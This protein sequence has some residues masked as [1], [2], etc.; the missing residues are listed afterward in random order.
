[1]RTPSMRTPVVVV[2]ALLAAGCQTTDPEGSAPSAS[3]SATESAAPPATGTA[4]PCLTGSWRSTDA[5][6]QA[7]GGG[8]SGTISGGS[9]ALVTI[10]ENGA[11]TAD[12]SG[13]QPADFTAKVGNTDVKG[14]FTYAG[15][16]TGTVRTG[17]G[18]T[19]AWEPVPPVD[20][21]D[22][23]LTVELTE[24][25][26]VKVFDGVKI[27]DYLGDGADRTGNVVD[28]DPF[29]GAGRYECRG[30]TLVLAPSDDTGITWTLARA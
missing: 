8:A 5:T 7:S 4:A 28:V 26:K 2:L 16:V 15:K 1:M 29:L 23:R 6:G 9:G 3:P 10:G 18:E 14:R 19:G 30:D 21:G 22:T 17:T 25:L 24:P 12:F 11:V 20:W 13:M 27:G